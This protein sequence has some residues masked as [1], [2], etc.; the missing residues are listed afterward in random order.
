MIEILFLSYIEE[1]FMNNISDKLSFNSNI[2]VITDIEQY[3]PNNILMPF[4][5]VTMLNSVE[6]EYLCLT[7]G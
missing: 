7:I 5:K 1:L 6:E 3:L 4:D 2:P